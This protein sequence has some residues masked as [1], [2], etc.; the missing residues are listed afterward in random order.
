MRHLQYKVM[1][2]IDSEEE[3]DKLS[4]VIDEFDAPFS[5]DF[6][7]Y[8]MSLMYLY[9]LNDKLKG[10]FDKMETDSQRIGVLSRHLIKRAKEA[11]VSQ[12]LIDDYAQMKQDVDYWKSFYKRQ[13]ERYSKKLGNVSPSVEGSQWLENAF[14]YV[15]NASTYREKL[16]KQ[17][18]D[19][20]KKTFRLINK[21]IE[22]RTK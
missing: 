10:V 4:E 18:M 7:V 1:G 15:E 13:F 3:S 14:G 20:H 19:F 5:D 12:D 2:T 9:P 17:K 21:L 16:R 22:R 6:M 11:E 8:W